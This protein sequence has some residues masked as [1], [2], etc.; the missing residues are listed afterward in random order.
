MPYIKKENRTILKSVTTALENNPPTTAGELNYILTMT[1]FAFLKK[2]LLINY[3]SYND[4]IGALES[5]KLEMYRRS[6]APYED[7]KISENGD[8][9]E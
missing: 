3:Q 7:I 1:C 6:V 9:Y 5:C 8:V 4:V 2:N